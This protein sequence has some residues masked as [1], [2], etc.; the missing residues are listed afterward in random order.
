MPAMLCGGL[1]GRIVGEMAQ[2]LNYNYPDSLLFSECP[3]DYI[4]V[5]PGMY[6]LLGAMAAFTGVTKLTVSL[7][8]IMF[9]LTGTINYIVPCM[10]TLMTS[11]A[12]TDYFDC[13]GYTLSMIFRKGYPYLEPREEVLMDYQV[14]DKMTSFEDLKCLY[15]TGMLK[16]EISNRDY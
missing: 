4:C 13:K 12:V 16:S 10:I 5:T 11:K 3:Q 9:E 7:T 15:G 14:Q 6:S 8:V 2:F 1:A